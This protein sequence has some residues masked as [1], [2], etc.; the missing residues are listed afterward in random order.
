MK[1]VLR[2]MNLKI[3]IISMFLIVLFAFC[4]LFLASSR[5]ALAENFSTGINPPLIRIEAEAPARIS[6]PITIENKSD[7]TVTYG[8]YLRPFNAGSNLNGVPNYDPELINNYKDFFKNV[9][10]GNGKEDITEISIP[11]KESR[12][13]DLRISVKSDDPVQDRYF[14][15]VFLADENNPE[16]ESTIAGARGGIGTN[17]LLSTGARNEPQGSISEFNTPKFIGKGP[18]PITLELTN[19][20]DFFM[21]SE[22]NVV[23]KNMFGQIVGN[24]EFE[25]LNILANSSRLVTNS[26]DSK[27]WW[28]EDYPVGIYKAEANIALSEHGPLLV[29]QI[30][31]VA[32]PLQ[33]ALVLILILLVLAWLFKRARIKASE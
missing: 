32:F 20:S 23:I 6:T 22:G 30:Y 5:L 26:D 24:L 3:R 10:V 25:S 17:V 29:K 16:L 4:F 12:Q 15:I 13:L 28:N 31:F 18:V 19:S 8:I 1:R 2:I 11:P 7:K 14:T 27:L 21:S 9:Q 33:I